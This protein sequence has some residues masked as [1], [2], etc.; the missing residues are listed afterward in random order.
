MTTIHDVAKRAGVAP[1]T[2]SRV[3]NNTG[4]I[5]P[6]T[7]QIVNKAIAELGYVPNVLAR[8]LRSKR[9]N[10]I[11]LVLTDITNPFFTIMARGV[12]DTASDAGFNVIFCNTDESE[13]KEKK[14]IQLLLQKQVDGILLVPAKS[15]SK[16]VDYV[17]ERD[18]P[19]V[20]LDRRVSNNLVDVVRCDSEGGAY[21]LVKLLI[22]LGHRRIALLNGSVDVSTSEDRLSGYKRAMQ[23]AGAEAEELYYYGTFTQ[24]SGYELARRVMAQTP[25]PTAIFAANNLI[26]IGALWA[27]QE[28]GLKV[29]EE[30][31]VVSFDDLPQS[32]VAYPFLTVATQPAY[33]MSKKATDLLIARLNDKAPDD[34]CQNIVLPVELIVRSSS[35]KVVS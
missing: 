26:A 35:G 30:I 8:S 23:E 1:I 13:E 11:A 5:S 34:Q 15:T 3:I 14:Y 24:A 7:R 32:L 12:E 21:Q 25:R 17:Q 31:A 4:Y 6:E 2:V 29:P 10:T 16:S 18:I 27:L 22:D 19:V 20:V 28:M 9:T 33:E